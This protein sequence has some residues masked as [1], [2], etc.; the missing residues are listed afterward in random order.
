MKHMT[1]L[2]HTLSSKKQTKRCSRFT[3]DNK[4][5]KEVSHWHHYFIKVACQFVSE[6]ACERVFSV[7]ANAFDDRQ[8]RA[9]RDYYEGKIM[10][11]YNARDDK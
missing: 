8:E 2:Y 9:L 10:C 1:T 6:A 7:V 11:R 4:D 5:N 3:F